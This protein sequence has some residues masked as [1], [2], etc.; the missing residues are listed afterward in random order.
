M[1]KTKEK[2]PVTVL[3]ILQYV[4]DEMCTNYCRFPYKCEAEIED[5]AKAQETLLREYCEKCPINRLM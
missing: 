1:K 2:N 4:S 5:E 3:D